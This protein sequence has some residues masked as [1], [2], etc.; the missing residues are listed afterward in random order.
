MQAL[1]I[2]ERAR[3]T[4]TVKRVF[5]EPI[6]EGGVIIVPVAKVSGGA[7]AGSGHDGDGGGG[8]G[9]H[10]TGIGVFEIRDGAVA[11]KPAIDMNR[12]IMGGQMVIIAAMIIAGGII[13]ARMKA[14]R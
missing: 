3:D 7:G 1:E 14:A 13:R 6:H 4:M 10:A 12:V 8:Y 9:M 2:L 5:G 11:F